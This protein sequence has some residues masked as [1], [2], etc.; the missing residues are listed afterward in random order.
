M[1]GCGK[2]ITPIWVKAHNEHVGFLAKQST[3]H[4]KVVTRSLNISDCYKVFQLF[5]KNK[6]QHRWTQFCNLHSNRYPLLQPLIPNS[7]WHGFYVAPRQFISMISCLKFGHACYPAYLH[8]TGILSSD[9]FEICQ[10][11]CDLDHIFFR[12]RKL[13]IS[14]DNLISTLLNI[15]NLFPPFDFLHLL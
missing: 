9:T 11:K 13:Q 14:I 3:A 6:W 2:T 12:C 5:L 15:Y 7:Y 4:I 8:K 1:S 10:V